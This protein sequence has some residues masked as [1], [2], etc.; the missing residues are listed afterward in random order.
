E[1]EAEA[2]YDPAI[3][4]TTAPMRQRL[5]AVKVTGIDTASKSFRVADVNFIREL[6]LVD[7]YLDMPPGDPEQDAVFAPPWST[8]PWHLIAL[9]EEAVSRGWAAFSQTEGMRRGVEGLHFIP[10]GD[11]AGRPVRR[12][13]AHW[14]GRSSP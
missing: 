3:A 4:S 13:G 12:G 5:R 1:G 11:L 7:V 6:F 10:L 14:K 2:R 8:L 9:M